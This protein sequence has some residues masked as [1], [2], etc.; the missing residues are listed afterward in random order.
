MQYGEIFLEDDSY[1]VRSLDV[2]RRYEM[3]IGIT[4]RYF[5]GTEVLIEHKDAEARS[6]TFG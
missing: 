3:I 5:L 4:N 6:G 1:I 2:F